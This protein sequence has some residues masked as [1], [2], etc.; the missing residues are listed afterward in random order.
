M[1]RCASQIPKNQNRFSRSVRILCGEMKEPQIVVNRQ[2]LQKSSYLEASN[3]NI[4]PA[5]VSCLP[6]DN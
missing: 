1:P 6:F 5:N 2:K 3:G 4:N